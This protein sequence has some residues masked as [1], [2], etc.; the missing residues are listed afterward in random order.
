M[1]PAVPA[2]RVAAAGYVHASTRLL[3]TTV[4]I[5]IRAHDIKVTKALRAHLGLRLRFALT[6]FGDRIGRVSVDLSAVQE[7]HGS[8]E[9]LCRIAVTVRRC[10]KVQETNADV[11]AA[12]DRAVDRAAR[13]IAR[14]IE[15]ENLRPGG[16]GP[17]HDTVSQP[18]FRHAESQTRSRRA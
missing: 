1:M 6:R 14:A 9:K 12:V 16:A 5:H 11:F 10:V 17:G 18:R 15:Q 3:E 7:R 13:S 4:E 8:A 2:V